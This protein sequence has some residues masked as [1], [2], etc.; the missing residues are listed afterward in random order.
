MFISPPTFSGI[1]L[2]QQQLLQIP[3][4]TSRELPHFMLHKE[5]CQKPMPNAFGFAIMLLNREIV[6]I[7]CFVVALWLAHSI[8]GIFCLISFG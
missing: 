6:S 3:H 1:V 5:I 7:R 8:I 2:L 4:L